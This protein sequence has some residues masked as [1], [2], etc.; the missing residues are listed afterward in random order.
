M[1][2]FASKTT[3]AESETVSV[4]LGKSDEAS[5]EENSSNLNRQDEEITVSPKSQTPMWRKRNSGSEEARASGLD[6]SPRI[7]IKYQAKEMSRSTINSRRSSQPFD[8][9]R[10]GTHTRHGLMPGPRGFSAAK[11]NQDRGVVCWPFNGSYNQALL[12][13]FDGHGSKGEKAS[14]FCMK[15]IPDLLEQDSKALKANPEECIS[16]NVILLDEMLLGGDL[17]RTAMTCGT[18]STVVYLRGEDCWVR[19]PCPPRSCGMS[20]CCMRTL[21]LCAAA[22]QRTLNT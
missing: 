3:A 7:S 13:V 6:R 1:G 12:C 18:T 5:S 10:I 16:R 21:K 20:G 4:T 17:G 8:R 14:E 22:P 9:S 11:I 15:S 19:L 2:C